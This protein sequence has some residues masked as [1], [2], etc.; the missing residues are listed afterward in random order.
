MTMTR[1]DHPTG[2]RKKP[3]GSKS[4]PLKKGSKK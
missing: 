3:A 4:K 1:S 2:L